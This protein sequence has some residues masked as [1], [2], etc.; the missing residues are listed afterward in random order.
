MSAY[1][2]DTHALI[3]HLTADA[4]LSAVCREIFEAADRGEAT[5]W[6]P[7]IVLV[8]TVYLAEK[9]RFPSALVTQMLN[10]VDPPSAGYTVAPLDAGV[11]RSLAAIDR[12]SVPDMPDRIVAATALKLGAPLLTRDHK[13]RI[14][15]G[16][17]AI[18]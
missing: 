3:W 13:I 17:Q 1:V 2:T 10:L 5:I 7:A 12:S 11:V 8:E 18:W 16:P 9:A 15:L 6:I 4:Q 14:A